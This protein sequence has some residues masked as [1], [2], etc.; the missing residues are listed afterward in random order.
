MA[1]KTPTLDWKLNVQR[2]L[3]AEIPGTD[4]KLAIRYHQQSAHSFRRCDQ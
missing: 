3:Q 1:T 2:E 4:V